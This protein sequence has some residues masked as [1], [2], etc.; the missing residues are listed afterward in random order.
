M[1]GSTDFGPAMEET[2]SGTVLRPL[3]VLTYNVWFREDLELHKRMKAI[4]DLIQLHSPDVICLQVISLSV[5]YTIRSIDETYLCKHL[6][7]MKMFCFRR[8]HPI[9]MTYFSNPIGG[10][11]TNAL[12]QRKL[13]IQG[14]TFACR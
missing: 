1:A 4:G 6:L 2:S 7:P 3:K 5:S 8:L 14:H 11:R 13:Q 10:R 9:Y 12:S